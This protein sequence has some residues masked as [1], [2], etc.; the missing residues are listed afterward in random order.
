MKKFRRNLVSWFAILNSKP[1]SL[2]FGQSDGHFCKPAYTLTEIII[3]LLVIAILV[4]V[5]ITITKAKLDNI[6]TYTYY[7]AYTTLRDVSRTMLAEFDSKDTTYTDTANLWDILI[8]PAYAF[9]DS[10]CFYVYK[11]YENNKEYCFNYSL[12]SYCNAKDFNCEHYIGKYGITSELCNKHPYDAYHVYKTQGKAAYDLEGT[13][14]FFDKFKADNPNLPRPFY[15]YITGFDPE[16]G[17]GGGTP[18]STITW[19]NQPLKTSGFIGTSGGY[20]DQN[21]ELGMTTLFISREEEDL[22]PEEEEEP[23]PPEPEKPESPTPVDPEEP[24]TEPAVPPCAVP[25]AEE[26]K[27]AYCAFGYQNFDTGIC[28]YLTKPA[29]WPPECRPNEHWNNEELD[30]RCVIGPKT[31]PRTGEN[32]C[33]KFAGYSNTKGNSIECKGDAIDD[34]LTDFSGKKADLILRNGMALYNVSQN[35]KEIADLAGNNPGGS[36]AGVPNINTFGYTVYVDVDG[37]NNGHSRLWEDVYPFYITMSGTVIPVYDKEH[38]GLSGGDSRNHLMVSVEEEDFSSGDRKIRWLKKSVSFKEGACSVSYV[39]T[40]TPY[41]LGV[42]L[43]DTCAS[44]YNS[45]SC[46]LKYIKPVKFLF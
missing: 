20:S 33:E 4:G 14:G 40:A 42:P 31:L 6:I 36:Y 30:C 18:L 28:D 22:D 38:P 43:E 27:R 37:Q 45:S 21:C 11:D 16:L 44:D 26:Q 39:G 7:S 12:E 25:S 34:G 41:C 10:D 3:V 19:E 13:L 9:E 35:P 5:G 24:D 46:H 1:V 32:F 29:V 23:T 17:G 2:K 8:N 15:I